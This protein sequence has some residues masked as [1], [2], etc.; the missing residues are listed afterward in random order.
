MRTVFAGADSDYRNARYVISGVPFDA[1]S[2]L[3]KGSSAAPHEIRKN[4]YNFETYS[5]LFDIDLLDIDIHDAGDLEVAQTVDETLSLI[6]FHARKYVDDGK[7]PVMLGGEHSI[8]LPFVQACKNK[9]P[10]LGFI[11]F[12]AHLDMRKEYQG[13]MNSHACVLRHVFENVTKKFVF[14]G[15]R[16]GTR[17][18]YEFVRENGIKMFSSEEVLS[19]G[20]EAAVAE[21]RE[22]LACPIY[23]SIDMDV[24]DPAYASAV[25]TPQPYGLMPR[26]V[27]DVISCFAPYFVGFDL[28]EITPSYDSGGTALLGAKLV[29]DFIAASARA[30]QVP[31]QPF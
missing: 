2:R 10:E 12:D 4:S 25:G 28:V 11:V 22:Y 5:H 7:I 13:E 1:T 16:S 18:E 19:A 24:M 21:I 31:A 8:T 14:I 3:R 9:Y 29:M 17:E 6:S 30:S 20:I 23:L 27:R 15:T 26:D